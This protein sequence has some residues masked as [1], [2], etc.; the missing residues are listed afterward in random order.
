ME[1]LVQP[2]KPPR[3]EGKAG[4]PAK[5]GASSANKALITRNLRL[6]YDEIAGEGIPDN[7]L[8][9]LNQLGAKEEKGS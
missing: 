3:R 2:T 4:K 5:T 1:S 9:L 8:E 6:V 7:M